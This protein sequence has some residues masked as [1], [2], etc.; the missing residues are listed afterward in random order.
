MLRSRLKGV[1]FGDKMT[2]QN[3]D[4]QV[5]RRPVGGHFL[6]SGQAQGVNDCR[7]GGEPSKTFKRLDSTHLHTCLHFC[8]VAVG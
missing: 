2:L 4:L 6:E 5:C 1:H 3:V 7:G 8:F